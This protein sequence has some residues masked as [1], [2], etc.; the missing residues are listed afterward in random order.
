MEAEVRLLIEAAKRG[1]A[2]MAAALDSGYAKAPVAK[3][4]PLVR[5]EPTEND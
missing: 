2:G 1:L 3:Q 5:Q 4:V